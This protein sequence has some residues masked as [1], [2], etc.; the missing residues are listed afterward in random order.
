MEVGKSLQYLTNSNE[1]SFRM[2][3]YYPLHITER[4]GSIVTD[5]NCLELI[6]SESLATNAH[7]ETGQTISICN[8][9]KLRME[10]VESMAYIMLD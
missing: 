6:E 4:G 9:W 10:A 3:Y 1:L 5:A 2:R 7:T 8:S